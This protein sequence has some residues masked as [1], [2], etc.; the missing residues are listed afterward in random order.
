MRDT[1]EGREKLEKESEGKSTGAGEGNIEGVGRR[2]VLV[3]KE[4]NWK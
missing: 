2:K 4:T 3:I 1:L